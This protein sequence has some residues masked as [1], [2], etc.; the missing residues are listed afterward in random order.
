[1]LCTSTWW[2]VFFFF[3]VRT[4]G[5]GGCVTSIDGADR[6]IKHEAYDPTNIDDDAIEDGSMYLSKASQPGGLRSIFGT[7]CMLTHHLTS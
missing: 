7:I 4:S 2:V 6:F 1:M 5:L 3:P